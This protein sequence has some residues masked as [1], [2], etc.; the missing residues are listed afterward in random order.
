MSYEGS[1]DEEEL[2]MVPIISNNNSNLVID[3]DSDNNTKN[4]NKNVLDKNI[5]DEV[6]TNPK[7]TIYA[8]VVCAMKKTTC[9]VQWQCQQN[10][11]ASYT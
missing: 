1:D 4:D 3:S 6:E 8:K 9:F 11:Q 5:D 10:H 7:T 2:K